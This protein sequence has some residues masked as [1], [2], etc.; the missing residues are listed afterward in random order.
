MPD[1]QNIPLIFT[2]IALT[3]GC[4]VYILPVKGRSRGGQFYGI[5]AVYFLISTVLLIFTKNKDPRFSL[6]YLLAAL[7]LMYAYIKIA[8]KI[9][10]LSAAY[11]CVRAFM[12]GEFAAAV[13]WL[14]YVWFARKTGL[15]STALEWGAMALIFLLIYGTV[16]YLEKLVQYDYHE[17]PVK[18]RD[19]IYTFAFAYAC[20]YLGNSVSPS[21]YDPEQV[22][23]AFYN[24]RSLMAFGS[25]A[26]LYASHALRRELY[27]K[28]ELDTVEYMMQLQYEQYKQSRQNEELVNMKY[29]DLKH[30]IEFLRQEGD[31]GRRKESL[32]RL[33]EEIRQYE[34]ETDTGNEVIDTILSEKK[35]YCIS[36]NIALTAVVDGTLLNF[37]DAMDLCSMIGNALDNAIECEDKI[38]DPEKR[39]IHFI[40]AEQKKFV[41]VKVENYCEKEP[42]LRNGIPET[43]KEKKE[44]HG[45]GLKSMRYI[46]RK[47]G[48]MMTVGAENNWFEI[49]ILLPRRQEITT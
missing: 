34:S 21:G 4:I 43:T 5:S 39:L 48:G 45:Y 2:V 47:Y 49:K 14:A 41:L 37:M 18:L 44:F 32:D 25:V 23:L 13:E 16:Y 9:D 22:P 26:I 6:L 46:A 3:L 19:F 28:K 40:V 20:F 35:R 17:M 30:Q 36:S 8:G 27:V 24:T 29:H 33:E 11:C 10:A 31:D 15:Y 42:D 38:T 7:L 1:I 12:L